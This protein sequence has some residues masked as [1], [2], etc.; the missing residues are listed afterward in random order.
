[1]N[2][3]FCLFL[4]DLFANTNPISWKSNTTVQLVHTKSRFW[5]NNNS[6]QF[7]FIT[8]NWQCLFC[9]LFIFKSFDICGVIIAFLAKCLFLRFLVLLSKNWKK[10]ATTES[11]FEKRM[12]SRIFFL[13]WNISKELLLKHFS[14]AWFLL[15]WREIRSWPFKIYHQQQ[16]TLLVF[17]IVRGCFYANKKN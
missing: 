1:M 3:H 10:F 9:Y 17:K 13:V 2:M 4:Q 15:I 7:Q 8:N 5:N 14:S 11:V 12:F 16:V 6:S